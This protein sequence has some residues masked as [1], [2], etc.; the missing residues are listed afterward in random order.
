[1]NKM[2]CDK[3]VGTSRFMQMRFAYAGVNLLN[4]YEQKEL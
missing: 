1:M 3:I 2:S 4:S